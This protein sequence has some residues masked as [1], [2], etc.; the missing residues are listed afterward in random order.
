MTK[1][2]DIKGFLNK[3]SIKRKPKVEAPVGSVEVKNNIVKPPKRR[4]KKIAFRILLV[5]G[6][7]LLF[8]LTIGVLYAYDRWQIQ[9]QKVTQYTVDG[10]VAVEPCKNI[11]NPE[12]WTEAFRPELYKE[13]NK[14][15]I[16]LIGSDA[17]HNNSFIGNTDTIML[18]IYDYTTNQAR[19]ISFPRDLYA[20]Y[21][22]KENG[23]TYYAKINSIFA[24]GSLYGENKDGAAVFKRTIER[25]T[26][27]KIQYIVVTRFDGVIKGIDAL[28][29]IDVNVSEDH[30]DVY[31]RPDMPADLLPSCVKPRL[32]NKNDH[33]VD[34]YCVFTFKKGLQHMDGIHALIYARMRELSTDFDRARRQQEVVNAIKDKVLGDKTSLPEKAENLLIMYDSIKDYV[35]LKFDLNLETMLAGLDLASKIK[36]QGD[37]GKIILD[38]YFAG[39][40]VI[41]KGEASNYNFADYSFK[42]VQAKLRLIEKYLD[43]YKNAPNIYVVNASGIAL[44]KNNPLVAIKNAGLWFMRMNITTGKNTNNKS[45]IEI[46]DYTSGTMNSTI[47]RLK[48]DLGGGSNIVVLTAT[49]ENGLKPVGK[50]NIGVYLYPAVAPTAKVAPST[51]Q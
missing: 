24:A 19:T 51:T 38:P 5:F 35:D 20:P 4:I 3:F 49:A 47:E 43:Y 17:R 27:E 33:S 29:G 22:Y 26:G 14:T 25:I 46:I 9:T 1:K 31:P 32:K 2:I 37:S 36:D 44:D 13:N 21:Q 12:C 30:T 11:L 15:V 50:E 45:G 18:V 23:P 8:A 48:K 10:A 28:G 39:G 7:L 41:I 42:Q 34:D 40:G 6:A 16:L